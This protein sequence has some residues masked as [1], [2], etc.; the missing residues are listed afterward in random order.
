MSNLKHL[1]AS[2]L[3]RRMVLDIKYIYQKAYRLL[4]GKRRT[5]CSYNI[6]EKSK[7]KTHTFFGYY[8]VNPFNIKTD[9]IIY[10][11]HIEGSNDC[12]V[13]LSHIKGNEE[14]ILTTTKA[15]N[16]QQGCRLRWLPNN[17]REIIF[18]DYVNEEYIARIFNVD[19]NAERIINTPLYDI[20]SNGRCGLSLNFERLQSKRPGYGYSCNKYIE[21][22]DCF[23]EEGIDLV[24][25]ENNTKTRIITYSQISNLPG[26]K[27]DDFSKNYLNHIAFSPSG[28]KFL[29][30][31]LTEQNTVHLASLIVYDIK[32]CAFTVLETKERVSHYVWEDDDHIICTAYYGIQDCHYYRYTIS[33]NSK[34]LL[35]PEILDEDGHPSIMKGNLIITDTY[36]N[37][38]GYQRIY[39][40]NLNNNKKQEIISIYSDCRVEGERRTDL[41]PR[42]DYSKE[43]ICFDANESQYRSL[44][45]LRLV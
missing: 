38:Y 9:E 41:H 39:L 23:E 36:P 45:L 43:I 2:L 8:D 25:I 15:W 7:K 27:S 35:C 19:S 14:K 1:L 12:Q 20:S 28:E 42:L 10:L 37:K 13:I 40:V 44:Y 31:W 24:D 17:S 21:K 22:K 29:F 3:P 11:R 30:F 32:K 4:Y 6:T 18:N 34:E 26:C 16:W 33:S 5:T